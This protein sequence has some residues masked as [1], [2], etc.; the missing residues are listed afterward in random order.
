MKPK[1]LWSGVFMFNH[2]V[3]RLFTKAYSMD[4][5]RVMMIRRIAKQQGVTAN[6]ALS[7]FKEHETY[8][9]NEE[10]P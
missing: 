3:H 5:A 2:N 10:E 8:Q 1:K 7:Y 4:Q 6:M 9:V